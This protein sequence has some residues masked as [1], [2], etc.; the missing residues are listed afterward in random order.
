MKNWR[1]KKLELLIL[2]ISFCQRRYSLCSGNS[3][4]FQATM[5]L[6]IENFFGLKSRIFITA[7]FILRHESSSET[8]LKGSTYYL[9]RSSL[10][11]AQLARKATGSLETAVVS[12]T[13]SE[14]CAILWKK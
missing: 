10:A 4:A 14:T 13:S 1:S 6:C 3:S 7:E 12:G 2:F 9:I 11:S 8:C 5:S